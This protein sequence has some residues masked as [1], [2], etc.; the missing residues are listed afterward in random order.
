MGQQ[1]II[2]YTI[3]RGVKNTHKKNYG[4]H[5]TALL[6]RAAV[7][8]VRT[9]VI[10]SFNCS[11]HISERQHDTGNFVTPPMHTH[12]L[13]QNSTVLRH[14]K[15]LAHVAEAVTASQPPKE[16]LAK[17]QPTYFPK[18]SANLY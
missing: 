5:K 14:A 13:T 10:F 4:K 9:L 17:M 16:R 7:L 2:N 3:K 15:P 11:R 12:T 1:G 6:S 18:S 8:W